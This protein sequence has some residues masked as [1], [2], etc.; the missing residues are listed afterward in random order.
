MK[1]IFTLPVVLLAVI[2]SASAQS[3]DRPKNEIMVSMG[4]ATHPEIGLDFAD[5]FLGGLVSD[6]D[7]ES[8]G[9]FAITYLRN[10]N[11]TLAWGVTG[12]YEHLNQKLDNETFYENFLAVMPT[13]RAYWF[14]TKYF[15]MYSRLAA[16][17]ALNMYDTYAGKG[18]SSTKENKCDAYMAFHAAP[19]SVE[20]G[21]SKF[22]GFM[23]IGYGYQGIV[24]LGVKVGF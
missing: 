24:N 10:M 15:G 11:K 2:C 20:L 22:S 1:R 21:T 23:E 3:F 13:V 12:S 18:T 19:V 14:R 7:V 5:V 17:L 16:G 6:S 8:D 4:I 9:A